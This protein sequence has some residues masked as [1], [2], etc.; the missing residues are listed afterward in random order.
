MLIGGSADGIGHQGNITIDAG[1][2]VILDAGNFKASMSLAQVVEIQATRPLLDG[3]GN[4][5]ID[6]VTGLPALEA[7]T[8]Q[9]GP[10]APDADMIGTVGGTSGTDVRGQRNRSI[11][12]RNYAQ[13]GNGGWNARG[14]HSGDIT[15]RAGQ[16]ADGVGLR[17]QGGNGREDYAQVGNGGFDSEGYDPLGGLNSDNNRLGDTGSRGNVSIDVAGD[18]TLQGGG[19]DLDATG[20]A[21]TTT[22]ASALAAHDDD[23]YSYAQ[24][25]HG[26]AATGGSNA[27]DISVVSREGSLDILAG[28]NSR[29]GY[30]MMGHGGLGARSESRIGD[31]LAVAAGDVWVKGGV[32]FFDSI[33][34]FGAPANTGQIGS[35]HIGYAQI[36]HG[37]WDSDP[38]GG[39]LN[40]T[41]GVGGNIGSIEVVSVDGS[42]II[43]GGGD[44]GL[45]R[46]DDSFFRG[47]SAQIGHGGNF[48][49]GDQRGD[50]RVAAGENVAVYGG[51]GGRDSYTMIGHGGLQMD[52]NLE[53]TIEVIAGADVIVNRGANTDTSTF[54]RAGQ[55]IF[56]NS[57]QIGHGDHRYRQ[58]SAGIGSRD[59]DI[60]ISAG[61]NLIIA[62]PAHRP[63]EDAAY[64]RAKPDLVLIGHIDPINGSTSAFR[65]TIGHTYLGASRT[66]PHGGGGSARIHPDA[67]I[68][69]AGSGFFGE[70]RLYLPSPA[71]NQIFEDA[72][73]NNSSYTRIPTPDGTRADELVGTDHTQGVGLFGE[74]DGAFLP[75]GPFSPSGFGLYN[76]YY[77]GDEPVDPPVPSPEPIAV[78]PSTEPVEIPA[79]ETEIVINPF[80]DLLFQFL[81]I[82]KYDSFDRDQQQIWSPLAG[83]LL[84][85]LGQ[86]ADTVRGWQADS[87]DIRVEGDEILEES[88]GL[89]GLGPAQSDEEKRKLEENAAQYRDLSQAH[90]QRFWTYN[91][92][93]QGYSSYTVF[94]VP[95]SQIAP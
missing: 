35:T 79:V 85:S 4:P 2:G 71:Q 58:R 13:I 17:V 55:E 69:S 27:G 22:N 61:R 66:N 68:T 40:L 12:A 70:L 73:F 91:V 16:T 51:A 81:F 37:G 10:G 41:A 75:E 72:T 93:S 54:D 3:A 6:P 24:I 78:L 26:G 5:V 43:Q 87:S 88:P 52:G 74:P 77:A 46:N 9:V 32:P 11:H 83:G 34:A 65:T 49:D 39:N 82:D 92:S 59:G 89:L 48:T 64:A 53:G 63:F 95:Y 28:N 20:A 42:V 18:V 31:I 45:T 76:I 1:G 80:P 50:I 62:D 84:T 23:R 94:G 38:Q 19:T 44:P 15:I 30:V 67:V 90:Y 7:F 60:F 21:G 56:N 8:I 25:G 86:F 47:L 36:G 14:D 57:A 29:Y 33:D